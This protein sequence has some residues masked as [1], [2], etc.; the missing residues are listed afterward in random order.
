MAGRFNYERTVGGP[1]IPLVL[2]GFSV[3]TIF[4]SKIVDTIAV[5]SHIKSLCSENIWVFLNSYGNALGKLQIWA[6]SIE[7]NISLFKLFSLVYLKHVSRQN[8]LLSG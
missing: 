6:K 8:R 7:W 4:S 1:N 2:D 5:R 3:Q